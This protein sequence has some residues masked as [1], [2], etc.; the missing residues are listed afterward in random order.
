MFYLKICN[1]SKFIRG[2]AFEYH[3]LCIF[4]GSSIICLHCSTLYI[5]YDINA[6]QSK[7]LFYSKQ[8]FDVLAPRQVAQLFAPVLEPNHF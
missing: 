5:I 1:P 2:N 8:L 7:I 3:I 4:V 6:M